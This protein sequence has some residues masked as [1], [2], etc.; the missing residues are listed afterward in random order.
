MADFSVCGLYHKF[1]KAGLRISIK[2]YH[3]NKNPK[4]RWFIYLLLIATGWQVW[5][6]A[7][8]QKSGLCFR[9]PL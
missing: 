4:I 5:R 8:R 1:M 6:M 7:S 9:R 2:D 3:R